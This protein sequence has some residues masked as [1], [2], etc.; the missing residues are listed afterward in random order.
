MFRSEKSPVN[1][2]RIHNIIEF[3]SFLSFTYTCRGLYENHK[4]LFTILLALKIDVQRGS[5]KHDEFQ[6]FIKGQ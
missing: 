5:V 4:F 6:V 2:K 3:L 1:S